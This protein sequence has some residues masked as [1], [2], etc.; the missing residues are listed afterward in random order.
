MKMKKRLTPAQADDI[1]RYLDAHK[2]RGA[3]HAIARHYSVT[4]STISAIRQGRT[5]TGRP[6][7]PPPPRRAIR[8]LRRAHYRLMDRPQFWY[9]R[10]DMQA[11][12]ILCVIA[13]DLQAGW[14]RPGRWWGGEN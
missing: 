6:R 1:R 10:G 14:D 9:D 4:D 5:H 2:W 11:S 7:Q 3:I 12:K 8:R 13:S